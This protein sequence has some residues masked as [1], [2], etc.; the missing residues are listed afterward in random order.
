MSK[1][2]LERLINI[3]WIKAVLDWSQAY[4]PPGFKGV[5]VYTVVGFLYHEFTNDRIL[6]RANSI[7]FNFMLA[8][9]PA[10]IFILT[11]IPY[12][13]F[14]ENYSQLLMDSLEGVM[15]NNAHAYLSE[16]VTSLA[17]HKNQGLQSIGFVLAV[18]FASNGML[19][20]MS[21]FNKSNKEFFKSRTILKARL[22]ALWLTAV[23]GLFFVISLL[24][25]ALGHRFINLIDFDDSK[26]SFFEI[27]LIG[28]KWFLTV[29][30]VYIAV[31][32]IYRYAPKL[33]NRI[34]FINPGSIMVSV[35]SVLTSI[36]FSWIVNKFG[37]YNDIYQSFGALV[38][39]MLW[40]QLNA[41]IILAGYELN[42]SIIFNRPLRT[43]KIMDTDRLLGKNTST[44]IQT[45]KA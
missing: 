41:F 3:P 18:I 15:P 19:S 23:I 16:I 25:V 5:P 39:I 28:I 7:A 29:S 37:R 38:V 6:T 1:K 2:W 13:P 42:T 8:I 26:Y 9:F 27:L 34:A 43:R 36:V 20:L 32:I 4:S 12:L 22:I 40:L 14:A 21:A 44:P 33:K 35:L 11:L 31:T 30:V 17:I 10:L 45:K 24:L